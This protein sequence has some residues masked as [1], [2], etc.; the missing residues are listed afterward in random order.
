MNSQAP[1]PES[2]GSL[3]RMAAA[4]NDFWFTPRDPTLLGLIR[5]LVGSITLYTFIVHGLTLDEFMGEHAWFD[6][7]LRKEL[8]A[9]RPTIAQPLDG[10]DAPPVAPANDL[11]A[12]FLQLYEQK[13]NAP[14]A[15]PEPHHRGRGRLCLPFSR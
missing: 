2:N 13:Y 14:F 11:Q 8:L 1:F 15:G 9:E 12:R 5:I 3:P 10:H 7:S 6:L 4:W